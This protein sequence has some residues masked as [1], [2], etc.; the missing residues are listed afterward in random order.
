MNARRCATL[1][2]V[3][4]FALA[5][6]ARGQS[7]EKVT[8]ASLDPRLHAALSATLHHPAGSGPFPAMVLLHTCGGLQ[9]HEDDWGVWFARAGYIALV[10]DSFGPRGVRNVCAGGKPDMRERGF[11][12]Y[13]ALAYLRG[14]SDVD[15]TRVGAIG[16]SHGAGTAIV[17]DNPAFIA[18]LGSAV[19]AGGGFRAAVALYPPCTTMG[20][21]KTMSAPLLLLV[22]SADDW[23][24]PAECERIADGLASAGFPIS[25]HVYPGATHAFDNA[26][27]R[28]QVHVGDHYYTMVYDPTAANDARERVRGFLADV[29]K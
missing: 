23:T 2:I 13:G 18:A 9:P 24:P 15:A 5:A 3:A 20:P 6:P 22:G 27:D 21:L 16:W 1:A 12:A 7:R 28:G 10:V 14:R 19:P 25:V 26:G 17:V 11:D 29:L 4:L 8:F